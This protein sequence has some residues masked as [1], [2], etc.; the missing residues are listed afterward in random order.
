MKAFSQLAA[1]TSIVILLV[2]I[3]QSP[4]FAADVNGAKDHPSFENY[5]A[6]IKENGGKILYEATD[7]GLGKYDD[8][9]NAPVASNDSEEGK[10]KN[11]RVELV[12]Q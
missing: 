9:V 12:K 5:K 2:Y 4:L 10:A 6:L 11:R 7:D 8:F 3:C 1:I